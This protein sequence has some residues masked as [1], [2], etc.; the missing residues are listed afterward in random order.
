M[1]EEV[2]DG[3][4]LTANPADEEVGPQFENPKMPKSKDLLCFTLHR[5][6]PSCDILLS[7]TDCETDNGNVGKQ[8]HLVPAHAQVVK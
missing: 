6:S 5:F 4:T 2:R 1:Y 7:K 3:C 8:P